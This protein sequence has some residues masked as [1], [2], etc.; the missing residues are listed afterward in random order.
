[1]I[2][3]EGPVEWIF[4][5]I[6]K[7]EELDFKYAEER[8]PTDNVEDLSESMQMYPPKDFLTGGNLVPEY[9]PKVYETFNLI[10]TKINFIFS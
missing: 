1:M 10:I 8:S 6:Q 5:E 2:R 4:K 3:K 7:V 9:K